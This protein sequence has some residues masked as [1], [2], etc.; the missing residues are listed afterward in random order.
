[1][2]GA[3]QLDVRYGVDG[4]VDMDAFLDALN[5]H[6]RELGRGQYADQIKHILQDVID[7]HANCY[8][9]LPHTEQILLKLP[10]GKHL[11][12]VLKFG[13]RA[14]PAADSSPDA[15]ECD[16]DDFEVDEI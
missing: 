5:A 7:Q 9:S 12:F 3:V 14:I 15:A 11:K 2:T 6:I 10:T 1:M 16:K 13:K 4:A 8:S